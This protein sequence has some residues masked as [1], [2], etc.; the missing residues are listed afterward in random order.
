[1]EDPIMGTE[2]DQVIVNPGMGENGKT[3]IWKRFG[4]W[5]LQMDCPLVVIP[6]GARSLTQLEA[7]K[8]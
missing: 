1:M 6:R 2:Y 4:N 8:L 7:G 5:V 3:H